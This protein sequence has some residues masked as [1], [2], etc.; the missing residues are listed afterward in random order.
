MR[1]K[2]LL[3]TVGVTCALCL[4]GLS[5]KA[6]TINGDVFEDGR[7]LKGEYVMPDNVTE[8][9]DYAFFQGDVTKVTV[10]KNLK[11][12]GKLAFGYC[13]KLVEVVFPEECKLE[14]IDQDAFADCSLLKQLILPNGVKQIED[15]AFWG[16]ANL[17]KIHIPTQLDTLKQHAFQNCEALTSVTFSD[18]LKVLGNNAFAGC[19][20]LKEVNILSL[21]SIATKVFYGCKSLKSIVLPNNLRAIADSA[22]MRCEALTAL[23]IPK[24]VVSIGARLTR[25]CPSFV[26][27]NVEEGSNNFATEGGILFSKDKRTLYECPAMYQSEKYVVP[28][29]TKRLAPYSFF[30]CKNVASIVIPK[31]IER[32]GVAALSYNGMREFFFEGNESYLLHDGALHYKKKNENGDVV[33]LALLSYPTKRKGDCSV[34]NGTKLIAQYAFTGAE[35]LEN[36]ILPA[37]IE[38]I[39]SCSM[40]S[41]T[42]LKSITCKGTTPPLV[43]FG[44]FD[45]TN[46]PEVICYVPKGCIETY[47]KYTSWLLFKLTEGE[48]IHVNPVEE[49]GDKVFYSRANHMLYTRLSE[50][51]EATLYDM[52]GRKIAVFLLQAGQE[53]L[54]LDGLQ[55][56]HYILRLNRANKTF[57]L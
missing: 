13:A 32:I 50:A 8:I 17:T 15:R 1:T 37:S 33:P 45:N 16:C 34:A 35:E 57:K 10:S 43:Y 56:G 28:Q 5:L 21:D 31:E 6:Q 38:G 11:K 23:T 51:D 47:A 7:S 53:A 49:Y 22:F 20:S 9:A 12:I 29:E 19:V 25:R 4:L 24:S 44:A 3:L 14:F 46:T 42:G 36:I 30:E 27:F 39:D 52:M 18:K 26:Q 54:P 40:Q 2:Q 41:L 48:Y 55:E